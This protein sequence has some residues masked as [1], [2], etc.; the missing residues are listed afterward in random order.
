V[1]ERFPFAG[2]K[3]EGVRAN[4]RKET[5]SRLRSFGEKERGGTRL[6]RKCL[7]GGKKSFK[8][9]GERV[10]IKRQSFGPQKK[11]GERTRLWLLQGGKRGK[12][13]AK[14]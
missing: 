13:K 12:K 4:K 14:Y 7:Q 8:G 6:S 1:E 11:K 9:R 2:K 10:V 5:E 3:K